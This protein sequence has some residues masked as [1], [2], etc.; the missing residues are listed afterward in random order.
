MTSKAALAAAL[1]V[2][3]AGLAGAQ[4]ISVDYVA[5]QVDAL[6][7]G[8]WEPLAAGSVVDSGA[9]LRLGPD[10]VVDL[11]SSGARVT[12]AGPGSFAIGDALA[13]RAQARRDFG[14]FL[15]SALRE[16]L[17]PQQESG[18]PGG[19]RSGIREPKPVEWA[20]DDKEALE[21]GRRLLLAGRTGEAA[22]LLLEARRQTSD[23]ASFDFLLACSAAL[24]GRTGAA[25]S[26]LRAIR[27][28]SEEGIALRAQLAL[29]AGS[30][31]EAATAARLCLAGYPSGAKA[32]DCSLIEGIALRALGRDREARASLQRTA[33]ADPQTE[34]GRLAAQLLR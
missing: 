8:R 34:A 29:D 21:G 28:D 20:D 6:L 25:L 33:A 1:F 12:L 14:A 31:E 30:Y 2:A 11:S 16:L 3:A 9:T 26:I 17:A 22:K 15:T 4:T 10:A 32:Q 24:E 5:G 18:S 13:R 27:L 7:G 19:A 23:T